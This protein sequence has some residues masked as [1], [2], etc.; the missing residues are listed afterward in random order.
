MGSD[1]LSGINRTFF[2]E[3]SFNKNIMYYHIFFENNLLNHYLI[4]KKT[5]LVSL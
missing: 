5:R 3:Y 4:R 1:F 2:L